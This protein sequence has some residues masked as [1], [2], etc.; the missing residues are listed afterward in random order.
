MLVMYITKF[1]GDQPVPLCLVV[2]YTHKSL[3]ITY[4]YPYPARL[5]CTYSRVQLRFGVLGPCT[6]PGAASPVGWSRLKV[7]G[8]QWYAV[9]ELADQACMRA[10]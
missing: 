10:G 9:D 3:I 6:P 8:Y 2:L 4:V 5:P 1:P 7:R